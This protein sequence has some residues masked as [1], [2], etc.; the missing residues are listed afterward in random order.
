M[1]DDANP[2][3]HNI[4]FTIP[5]TASNLVTK[6]LNLPDQP[7]ILQHPKDGYFFLPA[8]GYRYAHDTFARPMT[9]WTGDEKKGMQ[10]ALHRSFSAWEGWVDR[11]RGQGKGT[12]VKEHVNWMVSA[13]EEARFLHGEGSSND[14]AAKNPTAVPDAFLL[15][16]TRPTFLMRHPALTF[17]SLLRTAIDNEGWEEVG[18]QG[19]EMMMRWE[20]TFRWHVRLY[21][22]YA[23]SPGYPRASRQAD[24]MFPVVLDAADLSRPKVVKK[25]AAAVG[26]DSGLVRYE[27]DAVGEAEQ[28]NMGK[29][30]ARMKSTL[31]GSA[32]VV[33]GKLQGGDIDVEREREKWR[34]EFGEELSE[35]LIRLVDAAMGD[36]EWLR[37][38]K[39]RV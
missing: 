36:Y 4:L 19:M 21:E 35:R 32:G 25:Y 3:L 2:A 8:L 12:F 34:Q 9:T 18:K 24:V 14:G 30:E 17:P 28:K 38:R 23:A 1:S 16:D 29:M 11:A 15:H 22:F 10:D 26:L 7:A 6:L 31:L 13:E 27:W 33:A 39:L 5:R 20:C 37:K